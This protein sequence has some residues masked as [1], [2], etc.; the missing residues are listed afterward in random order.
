MTANHIRADCAGH[1][2]AFN[3]LGL[4]QWVKFE[5]GACREVIAADVQKDCNS[6]TAASRHSFNVSFRGAAN[7]G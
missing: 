2:P 7:I 6:P 1:A 4:G 5:R 3:R